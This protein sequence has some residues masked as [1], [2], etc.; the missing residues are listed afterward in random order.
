MTPMKRLWPDLRYYPSFYLMG[1]RKTKK[2]SVR[3]VGL[4][5]KI[6]IWELRDIKGE[7]RSAVCSIL[8]AE[9]IYSEIRMSPLD[10]HQTQAIYGNNVT[11]F[12]S[13][14]SIPSVLFYKSCHE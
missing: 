6:L 11:Y 3:T 10:C 1:L 9:V 4:R 12:S 2:M 13:V 14:S 8:H 7:S 5:T